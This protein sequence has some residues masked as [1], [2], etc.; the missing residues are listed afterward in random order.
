MT[1]RGLS[2]SFSGGP[3]QIDSLLFHVVAIQHE[4]N[5]IR[6]GPF[7][8]FLKSF[9][10]KL[11]GFACIQCLTQFWPRCMAHVWTNSPAIY[12]NHHCKQRDV[13]LFI[14]HRITK[15]FLLTFFSSAPSHQPLITS[16]SSSL[17]SENSRNESLFLSFPVILNTSFDLITTLLCS[18]FV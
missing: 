7:C 1:R 8:P 17:L 15:R 16:S 6:K 5:N 13:I 14:V 9:S 11:V 18:I 3:N 4:T 10:V 2:F 12:H